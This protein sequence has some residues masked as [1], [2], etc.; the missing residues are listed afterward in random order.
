M[1]QV[2]KYH[3]Q[4]KCLRLLQA[5]SDAAELS[6]QAGSYYERLDLS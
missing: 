1:G 2:M 3:V 6:I 5:R 4:T